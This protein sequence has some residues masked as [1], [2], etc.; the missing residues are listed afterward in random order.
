MGT[1]MG[2]LWRYRV[3]VALSLIL[4]VFLSAVGCGAG[5]TGSYNSAFQ[6]TYQP[7][8]D[9]VAWRIDHDLFNSKYQQMEKEDWE[10]DWPR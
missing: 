4:A 5:Y 6:S 8:L 3:V 9:M 10:D 7:R 2:P 1:K